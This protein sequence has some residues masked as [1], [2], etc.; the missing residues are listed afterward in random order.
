M[1]VHTGTAPNVAL[2]R[3]GKSEEGRQLASAC[4]VIGEQLSQRVHHR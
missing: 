2:G 4:N 3:W 1:K